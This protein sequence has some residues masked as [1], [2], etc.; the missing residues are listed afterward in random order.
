MSAENQHLE[1]D[2]GA[3]PEGNTAGEGS[4]APAAPMMSS[5]EQDIA[6][7]A[8]RFGYGP[9][10]HVNTLR[11]VCPPSVVNSSQVCTSRSSVASWPTLLLWA[12]LL[13]P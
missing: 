6:R 7:A 9:L 12:C 2:V 8:A 13:S 5:E 11:L 1:K 3:A 4:G 10:A